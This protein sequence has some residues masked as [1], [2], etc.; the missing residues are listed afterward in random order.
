MALHPVSLGHRKPEKPNLYLT[1]MPRAPEKSSVSFACIDSEIWKIVGQVIIEGGHVD[2]FTNS[3]NGKF[4]GVLLDKH[5]QIMSILSKEARAHECRELTDT[6]TKQRLALALSDIEEQNVPFFAPIRMLHYDHALDAVHA[7]EYDIHERILFQMFHSWGGMSADHRRQLSQFAIEK[8]DEKNMAEVLLAMARHQREDLFLLL[9]K[10]RA[11]HLRKPRPSAAC[12]GSIQCTCVS[13]YYLTKL[14]DKFYEDELTKE[15]TRI[16]AEHMDCRTYMTTLVAALLLLWEAIQ[17]VPVGPLLKINPD[18]FRVHFK[19]G[20]DDPALFRNDKGV[21][22]RSCSD[23]LECTHKALSAMIARHHCFHTNYCTKAR[24]TTGAAGAPCYEIFAWLDDNVLVLVPTGD[25]V[26]NSRL[27]KLHDVLRLAE[28][29]GARAL[30]RLGGLLN[31]SFPDVQ[32]MASVA[33]K[34]RWIGLEFVF[35]RSVNLYPEIA[36]DYRATTDDT[37]DLIQLTFGIATISDTTWA[38]ND[39]L[40]VMFL[41]E[42]AQMHER[43]RAEMLQKFIDEEERAR[44]DKAKK[45]GARRPVGPTRPHTPPPVGPTRPHTPPPVEPPPPVES[46]DEEDIILLQPV[47]AMRPDTPPPPILDKINDKNTIPLAPA[48]IPAARAPKDKRKPRDR[49]IPVTQPKPPP[50]KS[51]DKPPTILKNTAPPVKPRLED[52]KP[53]STKPIIKYLPALPPLRSL[54]IPTSDDNRPTVP[55]KPTKILTETEF[56]DMLL[57]DMLLT[58]ATNLH[59]KGCE[60]PAWVKG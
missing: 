23:T 47:M 13:R 12:D 48:I 40:M 38:E 49:S 57:A 60:E 8:Y 1:Q 55:L 50:G 41:A 21:V 28:K 9:L 34:I 29:S 7:E 30:K 6:Y 18:S 36:P 15:Q 11:K 59:L 19:L 25:I 52:K 33:D 32:A 46:D 54:P 10:I 31:N 42:V 51:N 14:Y 20:P 3:L 24:V 22:K 37:D 44:A 45:V 39:R 5:E 27:D 53:P 4:L 35:L 26:L 56:E 58:E 43:L 2:R 16:L 17:T